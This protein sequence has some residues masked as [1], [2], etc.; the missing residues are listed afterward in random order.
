M[1]K[2]IYLFILCIFQHICFAE[3]IQIEQN[4]SGFSI[5]S[6]PTKTLYWRGTN[7]KA[8]IL[9]IPGGDGN[10]GFKPDT[11]DLKYSFYQTLKSLTNSDLTSGR[12]DVV[13]M[14]FPLAM[15]DTSA[16]GSDDHLTRIDSAV[17]YYRMKTG[18]PIWIMGH[19]NGG[20][21]LTYYVKFLQKERRLNDIS[22]IIASAVRNG[23]D[24]QEP[25]N[26]P[27]LF[28]HHEKDGC[29]NTLSSYSYK[30]YETVKGF[31]SSNIKYSL[32]TTGDTEPR[33]PCRSGFHMY[34]NSG[35][36]ASE[37]IQNFISLAF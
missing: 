28:I 5:D 36:E 35:T 11:V 25:I 34:F 6:S 2:L 18:L 37:I 31:T 24:F 29:S 26:V 1:K 19:S 32:L 16:R 33:D 14:D 17:H 30:L 12:F 15:R 4:K 7:A 22:G 3:I 20:I 23:T 13:V 27:I 8:L 10:I 9:F 21:S